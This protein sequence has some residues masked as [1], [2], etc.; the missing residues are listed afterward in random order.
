MLACRLASVACRSLRKKGVGVNASCLFCRIAAHELEAEIVYE[1]DA[2]VAFQDINPQAPVHILIVPRAHL[3][4]IDDIVPEDEPVMGRLVL[5]ASKIARDQ[6]IVDGG[7]R[8]VLNCGEGAGQSVFHV[9]MH[10]L[11]GRRFNWP[12][13]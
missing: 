8:L 7:Y 3:A 12:P 5:T 13:G 9:H 2:V 6:G 11:G 1:D 4:S 10:L